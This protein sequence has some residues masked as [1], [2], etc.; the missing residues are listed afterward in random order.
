MGVVVTIGD[1][2]LFSKYGKHV[3]LWMEKLIGSILIKNKKGWKEIKFYKKL[4]K[5]KVIS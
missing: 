1:M 4:E 3:F 5:I 2:F